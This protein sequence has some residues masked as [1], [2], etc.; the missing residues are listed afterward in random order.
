MIWHFRI[1]TIR[2]VYTEDWEYLFEDWSWTEF[3]RVI[4]IYK[5]E[6]NEEEESCKK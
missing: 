2:E 3:F 4:L 6:E 1:P 5:P